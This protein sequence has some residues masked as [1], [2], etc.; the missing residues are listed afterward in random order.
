[1]QNK[2]F[3]REMLRKNY[4]KLQ[5]ESNKNTLKISIPTDYVNIIPKSN[6]VLNYLLSKN[7]RGKN[8]SY[9]FSLRHSKAII[10]GRR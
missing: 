4:E 1:M 9:G 5:I 8:L 2:R 7:V 6:S 10:Y 3:F